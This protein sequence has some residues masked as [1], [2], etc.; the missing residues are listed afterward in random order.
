MREE[1]QATREEEAN[2]QHQQ[3]HLMEKD[4]DTQTT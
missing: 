1:I 3:Q 2:H 4:Y